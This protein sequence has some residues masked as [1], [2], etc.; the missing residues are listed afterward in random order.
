MST[1]ALNNSYVQSKNHFFKSQ[2]DAWI[3]NMHEKLSHAK[4][5]QAQEE[6]PSSSGKAYK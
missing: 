4:Y 3:I 5:H 1:T 6:S 2:G